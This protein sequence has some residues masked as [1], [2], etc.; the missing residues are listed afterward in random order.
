M[1]DEG[2]RQVYALTERVVRKRVSR[3][4][5]SELTVAELL[6]GIQPSRSERSFVLM[7]HTCAGRSGVAGTFGAGSGRTIS[8]PSASEP[9]G[10]TERPPRCGRRWWPWRGPS[11]TGSQRCWTCCST[12]RMAHLADKNA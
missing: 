9:S 6:N 1:E 4:T 3:E 8:R 7:E 5:R 2:D 11:K 12:V 10:A